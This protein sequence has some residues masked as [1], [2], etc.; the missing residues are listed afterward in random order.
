M[1]EKLRRKQMHVVVAPLLVK[2][3]NDAGRH[4]S[5]ILEEAFTVAPRTASSWLTKVIDPSTENDSCG[6]FQ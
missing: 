4:H 3:G 2:Q 5:V 1:N 6:A